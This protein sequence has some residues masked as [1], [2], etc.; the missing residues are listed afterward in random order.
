[1]TEPLKVLGPMTLKDVFACVVLY[2]SIMKHGLADPEVDAEDAYAHA[3]AMLKR[4]M[5]KKEKTNEV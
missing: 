2:A 5:G 4:R 1:M 3:E